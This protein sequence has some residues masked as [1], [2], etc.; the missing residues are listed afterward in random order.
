[1]CVTERERFVYVGAVSL[2]LVVLTLRGGQWAE[3]SVN[4]VSHLT[5]KPGF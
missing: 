1:M 5:D 4:F 3:N 2:F